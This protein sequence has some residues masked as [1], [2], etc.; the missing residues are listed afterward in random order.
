MMAAAVITAVLATVGARAGSKNVNFTVGDLVV[1][2]AATQ[3]IEMLAASPSLPDTDPHFAFSSSNDLGVISISVSQDGGKSYLGWRSGPGGGGISPLNDTG[4]TVLVVRMFRVAC[5][6]LR[7]RPPSTYGGHPWG[8]W[9]VTHFVPPFFL[10][11][12]FTRTLVASGG[13]E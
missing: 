9:E 4:S 12:W 7:T 1:S 11:T 8:L 2:F 5:F 13:R 10:H 3:T 6:L